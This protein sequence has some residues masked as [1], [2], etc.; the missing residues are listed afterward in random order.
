GPARAFLSSLADDER[1]YEADVN[2]DRAHTVMLAEQDIIPAEDAS[3]ILAALNVVESGAY[4]L[5]PDGEDIHEA[6]E[7]RVVDI[8]G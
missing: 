8:A 6:I 3:E 7:A 2:V 4:D 5:L 1:L